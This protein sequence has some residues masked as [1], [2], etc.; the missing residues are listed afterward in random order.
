MWC[1]RDNQT[2]VAFIMTRVKEPD[3]DDWLKL[4]RVLK[5]LYGVVYLSLTLDASKMSLIRWW[6]D[7]LFAV[8]HD[9][10]SH[11]GAVLLLGK[12]GVI[13]MSRKQKLNTKSS[14]EAEVVGVDDASSQILWT[15]Y[16]I[17]A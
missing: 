17:K 7:A 15:N 9:L 4:R 14:T 5:Y 8:H 10:R 12:G 13:S 11:M 1:Q 3:E 2:A 16:F 6:V